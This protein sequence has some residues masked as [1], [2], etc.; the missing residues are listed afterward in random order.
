[1]CAKP[2]RAHA[3]ASCAASM[4][5]SSASL[6]SFTISWHL[7]MHSDALM[8]LLVIGCTLDSDACMHEELE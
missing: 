3:E 1:M 2:L 8:S 7:I 5:E 6:K 4:A